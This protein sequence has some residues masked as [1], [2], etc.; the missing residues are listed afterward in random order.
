M[1]GRISNQNGGVLVWVLIFIPIFMLM[2]VSA[3][4]LTFE[5]TQSDVKIQRSLERAVKVAGMQVVEESQSDSTIRLD[6]NKAH[7]LFRETLAK[8]LLLDRNT[9]QPLGHSTLE[10]APYYYFIVYNGDDKYHN[11][12]VTGR[13]FVHNPENHGDGTFGS[14]NYSIT[15]RPRTFY[16]KE[17]SGLPLI[18]SGSG[19]EAFSVTFKNPGVA[20]VVK[21]KAK[22]VSG[23]ESDPVRW[24]SATIFCKNKEICD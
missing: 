5:V 15:G 21:I 14:G 24:A 22:T 16:I 6:C 12:N 2:F 7:E 17:E 1:I 13:F 20:A 11:P 3:V 9:L 10:E 8:N 18:A 19:A 4:N 23:A